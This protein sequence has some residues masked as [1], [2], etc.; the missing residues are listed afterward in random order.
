MRS[1]RFRA[2]I[3]VNLRYRQPFDK[4]IGFRSNAHDPKLSDLSLVSTLP[5]I[6]G[7]A[8][9]AALKTYGM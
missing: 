8:A 9:R 7:T 4:Q 5:R 6:D 3:E 2:R 1:E